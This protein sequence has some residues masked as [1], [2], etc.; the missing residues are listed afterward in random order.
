MLGDAGDRMSLQASESTFAWPHG[1]R[2]AVSLSF[3]DARPSQ[4][5]QGVPILN[6]QGVRATFYISP[7][8]L[9]GDR[10]AAWRQAAR[11]GHEIGNHTLTHPCSGNHRFSRKNAVEDYTLERMEGELTGAQQRINQLIGVTPVT[12]AYP[13]GQT[14][15]GRGV[16]TRSYVPLV[17]KH[18]LVGRGAFNETPNDPTFCDLA[19]VGSLDLDDADWGSA[20][21]L[22]DRALAEGAWLI[23]FGHEVGEGGHQTTRRDTLERLCAHCRPANSGV[24]IDTVAAI[25]QY[26]AGQR[27]S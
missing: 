21:A 26:V 15:V 5:D 1:A 19:Q 27:L 17:G 14:F 9:T 24:W 22:I 11:D 10:P 2:C 18:F 7:H 23:Y 20:K 12:F 4:I 16:G 3:D 25:G 13:C 6:A 8:N